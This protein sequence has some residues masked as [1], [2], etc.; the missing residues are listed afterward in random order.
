VHAPNCTKEEKVLYATHRYREMTR[1]RLSKLEFLEMADEPLVMTVPEAGWK[2]FRLKRDA[3]YAAARRGDIP[4]IK[5]G[6]AVRVPVRAVE[7]LLKRMM[8]KKKA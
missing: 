4:T 3:A 1:Y 8:E 2:Y 7:D 5:L 6:G